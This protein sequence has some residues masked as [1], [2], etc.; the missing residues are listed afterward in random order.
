[1]FELCQKGEDISVRMVCFTAKRSV[2]QFFLKISLI[3]D[4]IT[5]LWG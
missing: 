5:R 3:Y 4:L 2:I 1:M